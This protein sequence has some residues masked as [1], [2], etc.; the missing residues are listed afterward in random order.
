MGFA[1]IKY[2]PYLRLYL[3]NIDS[4]KNEVHL[5][6]WDRDISKDTE[7]DLPVKKHLFSE[8]MD[9]EIPRYKKVSAFLRYAKTAKSLIEKEKFDF[10]VVLTSIPAVLIADVLL[11][12]YKEKYIFDYRDFT[13]ENF[14]VYKYTIGKLVKNSFFTVYTS[15]KHLKYLPKSEKLIVVRNFVTDF[16]LYRNAKNEIHKKTDEPVKISYWGILRDEA[17]NK[18][19]IDRF[20]KDK[21]FIVNFY[22]KKQRTVANLEK[23]CSEKQ[24]E[25]IKF[26]GEYEEKDKYDFIKNTD[27]LYNLYNITGTEGMAMGNKFFDGVMF[28][29]PQICTRGSFMGENAEKYGVGK[30]IEPDSP[31]FCDDIYTYYNSIDKN[32]FINSC[33]KLTEQIMNE[34]NSVAEKIKNRL[35]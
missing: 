2:M 21:R 18:K 12:S 15:E 23:Y 11:K 10:I 30:A 25:N 29:I 14:P 27:I 9:D 7:I 13:Y 22:G 19:I 6:Y 26:F 28:Y 35:S 16:Q 17:F 20:A 4:E 1:K 33:D 8:V 32:T 31:N 24:I 34:Y 3:D 5:L